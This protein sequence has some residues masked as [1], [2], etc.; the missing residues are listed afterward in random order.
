MRASQRGGSRFQIR[1]RAIPKWL[2]IVGALVAVLVFCEA[3]GWPFLVKPLQSQLSKKLQREVT[4]HAPS[5][6][7]SGSTR[8]HLL[9]RVRLK[10]DSLYVAAPDWSKNPYFIDARGVD[11]SVPYSALWQASRGEQIHIVR[12]HADQLNV[13]AEREK[14]GRSSWQFGDKPA[15]ATE[16]AKK[17][18]IP[19]FDSLIVRQGQVLYRDQP[20][21]LDMEARIHTS[22]GTKAERAKPTA[23]APAAVAAA[24][25]GGPAGVPTGD[26]V[27]LVITTLGHY[28]KGT[29]DGKLTASGA[30]PLLGG[31]SE[32]VPLALNFGSSQT[33]FTFRGKAANV[34]ALDGITGEFAFKGPSLGDISELLDVTLPTT[35]AFNLVGKVEQKAKLW[36]VLIDNAKI[37]SSQLQ[38]Q[39][40]YDTRGAK[41][42]LSGNL[43]GQRVLLAD[44][45]PSI[46]GDA[47]MPTSGAAKP[48]PKK[49]PDGRALPNREFDLPS[50][51]VMNANITVDV[52]KL[53]L[54]RVFAEPLTP[55]R[56]QLLLN[57]GVVTI[58]DLDATT[59]G[60]RL[61]GVI[62]LDGN[63]PVAL[64]KTDL[65]WTDVQMSK[66]L[67]QERSNGAPPWLT[68]KL[69]GRAVL[70]G[71]G[72]ST[73]AILGT[74]EGTL[75]TSLREGSVSH[76]LIEG[77]GLDIAQGLGVFVKGD[78]ALPVTCGVADFR[79]E[80]GVLFPRAVLL[81]TK[82]S[83]V[84]VEGTV[85]LASE[86]LDLRAVVAPKDFSPLTL[87][88]PIRVGGTF[89]SPK[90]SL[91]ASKLA[92]KAG[93]A[94]LLALIN[95]V[96]AL[97]PLVDTG[98]GNKGSGC[99]EFLARRA[100]EG[101][102]ASM[103]GN[104][105]T[106]KVSA[107][108]EAVR[109]TPNARSN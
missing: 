31:E 7:D 81:D 47:P 59:A 86:K 42:I 89:E 78:D 90:V 62:S 75:G 99:E 108:P 14:D 88:A 53:E 8:I 67:K 107:A 91:E 19:R 55:V 109:A 74:L 25:S 100:N 71:Q 13:M 28:K 41:P 44:L 38:A 104:A 50:L 6:P 46:G 26:E 66:W 5:E 68:G 84:V 49:G 37:G 63:G 40:Q 80:K 79:A 36:N 21:V 20:L 1:G 34:L 73:G 22:E 97:I 69:N 103:R 52:Q 45:A 64:W 48:P 23:S 30:L 17:I 4:F 92:P 102:G 60:G 16:P 57:D 96:A 18:K 12:L 51:Q 11:L 58:K 3:L 56:A 65:R 35:P 82:D 101:A 93:I 87:R 32:P 27:G 72:R 9:G 10:S 39:M 105:P 70:A 15:P 106:P 29:F 95:P 94:A 24:S 43:T 33:A 76:L 2:M 61:R 85:S 77:A 83:T 98:D 54:G